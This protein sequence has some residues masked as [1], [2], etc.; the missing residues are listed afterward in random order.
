MERQFK[1]GDKVKV[2]KARED[3]GG[4]FEQIGAEG[5]IIDVEA[6]GVVIKFD[7]VVCDWYYD[8]NEIEL[9][10]QSQTSLSDTIKAFILAEPDKVNPPHYKKGSVECIDAIRAATVGKSGFEGYLVGNCVKYLWR[11]EDKGG[12]EDLK[13][14]AWYLNK[15]IDERST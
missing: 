13:K 15:L 14:A 6:F 9:V 5:T 10:E 3:I 11:F 4:A 2:V 1:V 8:S 7:D 12:V